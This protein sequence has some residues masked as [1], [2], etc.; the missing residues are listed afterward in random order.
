MRTLEIPY[1]NITIVDL[2]GLEWYREQCGDIYC[3][4]DKQCLVI[5]DPS[6]NLRKKLA[7]FI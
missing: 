2:L 4:G 1:D 6:E 7:R 5:V 3:D